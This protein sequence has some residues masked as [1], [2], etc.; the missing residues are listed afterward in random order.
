MKRKIGDLTRVISTIISRIFDPIWESLIILFLLSQLAKSEFPKG[1][2]FLLSFF[3]VYLIPWLFF[4]Y[5]LKKGKISDWDITKRE[6]RISFYSVSKVTILIFFSILFFLSPKSIPFYLKFLIPFLIFYLLTFFN[7][8]S[9]HMITNTLFI[10]S[11]YFYTGK[12]DILYIGI[13]ILLL[14]A[15]SRFNLKKHTLPQLIIGTGLGLLALI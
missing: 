7:K 15:L 6:E 1:S 13:I 3:L 14:V 9:G 12:S 10:L 2:L 8:V 5:Q 4:H 11:I